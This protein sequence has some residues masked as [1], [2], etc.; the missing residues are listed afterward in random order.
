MTEAEWLESDDPQTMLLFLRGKASD[1][2]L[3]LFLCACG[4]RLK[5]LQTDDR[6]TSAI[7]TVE[8]YVDG[9]VNRSVLM[10]ALMSA[11]AVMES[12]VGAD[13]IDPYLA[14]ATLAHDT[15]LAAAENHGPE[16]LAGLANSAAEAVAT[17]AADSTPAVTREV[18]LAARDA[19]AT[20]QAALLREVLGNP[21]RP[22]P[23]L[24]AS[25]LTWND[26]AVVKS[27]QAIY[28][29]RAFSRMLE[30]AVA[31]EQAGCTDKNILAHCRGPG[32]H[33]R[34]CW[35]LDLLLGKE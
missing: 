28:D 8:K 25:V 6:C 34:G 1:R 15:A 5:N 26:A 29:G 31:L 10:K 33:V 30:V 35:V 2:K 3:L 24:P 12:F 16:F 7:E 20:A 32:P 11:E 22:S 17:A 4:W 13:D 23:P 21:F 14:A 19:E 18:W 9:K 27:A